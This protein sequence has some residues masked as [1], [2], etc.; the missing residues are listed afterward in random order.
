VP[1]STLVLDKVGNLYGTTEFGG[2][3]GCVDNQPAKYNGSPKGQ[4]P[5]GCGT[6]F[7]LLPHPNG[8]WSEKILYNF[9][10]ASDGALPFAGVV[11]RNGILYGTAFEG[12][13]GFSHLC[14]SFYDGGCGVVYSLTHTAGVWTENVL[15]E[16]QG[17]S[18]GA[19]P[20]APVIFDRAGNMYGTT[21]G[22]NLNF[23]AY[24][25][26]FEL[27]PSSGGGWTENT[28]LSFNNDGSGGLGPLGALTLDS[29][30][31]LYG[32]T[33]YGG[34]SGDPKIGPAGTVFKLTPSSGTWTE[35]VLHSFTGTPDGLGPGSAKLFLKN[36]AL[37]GTTL[38]GGSASFGTVYRI[39][40]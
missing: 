40:P 18:D 15:Y 31:N 22:E 20:T 17:L 25:S 28:I 35:T 36:G 5:V 37:Y 32:T 27:S 16:F 23:S 3:G 30:G 6:V 10:G 34:A 2:T 26:V 24:S 29:A 14:G 1:L 19:N 38:Y 9:Q 33:L 11:L 39:V 4:I 7:E 8:F 21:N 12:G 13:G